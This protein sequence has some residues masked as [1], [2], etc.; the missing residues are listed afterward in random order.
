[1]IERQTTVVWLC[2]VGTATQRLTSRGSRA[3]APRGLR[4]RVTS[5]SRWHDPLGSS[6][7]Q[8]SVGLPPAR[9]KRSR[10][11]SRRRDS[12]R[13]HSASCTERDARSNELGTP[14]RGLLC[15]RAG[16]RVRDAAQLRGRIRPGSPDFDLCVERLVADGPSVATP[17]GRSGPRRSPSDRRAR[18]WR[19]RGRRPPSTRGTRRRRKPVEN[20]ITLTPASRKLL[21]DPTCACS[22]SWTGA[23]RPRR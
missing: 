10:S 8:A 12:C 16:A 5:V 11:S 9:R 18:T 23:R 2:G 19:R 22:D 4:P 7:R 3:S 21:A 1:M 14:R 17:I 15:G 6:D 13:R 20:A